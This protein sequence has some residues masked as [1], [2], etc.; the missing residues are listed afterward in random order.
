MLTIDLQ[1]SPLVPGR[2]P[3][4]IHYRD[5]GDGP[6]IV[7]LHGG[8]GYEVYPFDRQIAALGARH[9]VVIP[10]RSGYGR[11]GSVSDF[12]VDFHQRA[13]EETLAVIDALGL[14]RPVL[15]GHSDGAVIALMLGLAAPDR[16]SGA[17]VEAAHFYKSKPRS[18][19]FFER[20]IANP[21]SLGGGVAAALTRDHGPRGREMLAEHS[22]T[23]LRIT[24]EAASPADD[25]Y[26]GRLGD[27]TV[28]LLVVHGARD[29]RTEP[30]EL[31]ALRAALGSGRRAAQARG[32]AL[33][34]PPPTI[35]LFEE[36]GHSPHSERA[37]ADEVTNV[38]ADF[39]ASLTHPA[40]PARPAHQAR[41]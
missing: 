18:R 35:A 3:V 10:D 36:G 28:P 41:S 8:W 22:R 14:E 32:A 5:F 37:T 29:P 24:A 26:G 34:G 9:R 4:R 17:I 23:W 16:L 15:W 31:D 19:A 1:C 20:V 7:F 30:G 25:F 11:S 39:L 27:L 38:A 40:D 33:S 13:M 12:P 21:G 6:A 2:S